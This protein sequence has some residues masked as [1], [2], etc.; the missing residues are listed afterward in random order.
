MALNEEVF[1]EEQLKTLYPLCSGI[2]I[3]SQYD[4]DWYG[5]RVE[6]DSTIE[7]VLQY[8]DPAGKIHCVVRRWR[9]QAAALN[10][11]MEALSSEPHEGIDSHGSSIEEINNLHDTPDYFL[12]VD[13]DEFYDPDTF[14]D[15]LEYLADRQPRA[16][17]VKGLMYKG[18]WNRRVPE[19]EVEFCQFGFVRPGIL[20]ESVRQLTWN[21]HR[22]SKFLNILRLP[23]FS[24]RLFG[25]V[26][27]PEDVGVF[28]HGC[29]L[30]DRERLAEKHRKSAHR[31]ADSDEYTESILEM[32]TEFI[33]T[34][35]LP[36]N[37]REGNWPEEFLEQEPSLETE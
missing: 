23:D 29:W 5:K 31:W 2:S 21:E 22:L 8:P 4:R 33:K 12:I 32:P 6:P 19:E 27:C 7:R 18:S 13:A 1:I 24:S 25:F 11:E 17:R 34:E 16:M 35:E 14:G 15:I 36:R 30:G 10:M 20:F 26:T 9:D 37:I 28:H 3:L